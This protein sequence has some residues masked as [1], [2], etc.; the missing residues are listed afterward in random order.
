MPRGPWWAPG[1]RS[2][3][4]TWKAVS[5]RPC[6]SGRA[7]SWKKGRSWPSWKTSWP[8]ARTGMPCTSWWNTV[9]PSC[10]WRPCCVTRSRSS[11]VTCPSSSRRYWEK[12]RT[13]SLWSAPVRSS[14]TS[15]TPG[16]RKVRNC[17]P[18]FPCWRPSMPSGK[19]RWRSS[20]H[21]RN[22]WTAVWCWRRS[23]GIRPSACCSATT[24]PAWIIWG[25]SRRS[26]RPRARSICWPRPFPRRRP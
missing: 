11:P 4:P 24:I 20:W 22:S 19:A 7:R 21:A 25:W 16:R 6:S 8:R 23:S 17:G 26:S 9:W 14:M 5:S 18:S 1:V 13:A 3:S 10:G 12:S 2:R 15:E